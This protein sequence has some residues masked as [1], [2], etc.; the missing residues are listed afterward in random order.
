[1]G[2]RNYG[3]QNNGQQRHEQN[4]YMHSILLR[5]MLN[6]WLRQIAEHRL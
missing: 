5:A 4:N 1:M 6:K 3:Q 2:D